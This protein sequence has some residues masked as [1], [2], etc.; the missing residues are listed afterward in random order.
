M[1]LSAVEGFIKSVAMTIVSEIGDKTF[2]VAALMAMRHPRRLV[3]AG[4]FGALAMMTMLSAFFGWAAPNLISRRVTH[5]LATV[6]FFIFGFRSFWDA[7]TKDDGEPSELAEVEAELSQNSKGSKN[8]PGNKDDDLKKQQRPFL[9]MIFSPI[10]LEAFSVTFFGEWGDK[11]QIATIGL[12][13]EESAVGVALG[14]ILAHFLCST[15]AV[16]GGKHLASRISEKTVA[17]CGA[18]VFIAFG[19]H[20][21][22]SNGH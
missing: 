16:C 3:F 9:R 22:L 10:L 1:G 8:V 21:L 5:K 7:F 18:F 11:S 14:G 6:L 13:A 2:I 4:A 15:I 19:V 12:A 17:Y 20:S